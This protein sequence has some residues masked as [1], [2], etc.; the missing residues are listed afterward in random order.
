MMTEF[1]ILIHIKKFHNLDVDSALGSLHH[2]DVGSIAYFLRVYADSI[3]RVKVSK[4]DQ[5]S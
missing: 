3:Y 4:V 1:S 2:V 5:C